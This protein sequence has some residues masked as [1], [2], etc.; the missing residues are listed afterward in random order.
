MKREKLTL[1]YCPKC[2]KTHM[3]KWWYTGSQKIPWHRCIGCENTER[4]AHY[5]Y[6]EKS[7]ADNYSWEKKIDY[8][9]YIRG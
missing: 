8:S 7:Y 2:E 5:T 3:Y 4:N 9:K 1:S 6:T